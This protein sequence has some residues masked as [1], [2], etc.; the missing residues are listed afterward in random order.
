MFGNKYRNSNVRVPSEVIYNC[1]HT[2]V[3][4]VRYFIDA[5]HSGDSRIGW[6]QKGEEAALFFKLGT[7]L[8]LL[9]FLQT[10]LFHLTHQLNRFVT[11][12]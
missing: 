7:K 12:T 10:Y 11:F 8:A 9:Y 5:I 1:L 6:A 3:D 2:L 4:E